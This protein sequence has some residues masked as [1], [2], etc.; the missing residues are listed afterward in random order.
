MKQTW[1]RE[2]GAEWGAEIDQAKDFAALAASRARAEAH[3]KHVC[4]QPV[5]T[6]QS[7]AHRPVQGLTKRKNGRRNSIKKQIN[8]QIGFF[9]GLETGASREAG[10]DLCMLVSCWEC[11]CR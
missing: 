5:I 9:K 7:S 8:K 2:G 3:R 10:S 11:A 1:M 6:H 4:Q